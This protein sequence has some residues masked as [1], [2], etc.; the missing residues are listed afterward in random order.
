M[1]IPEIVP[2]NEEEKWSLIRTPS[3][4][5]TKRSLQIITSVFEEVLSGYGQD[6]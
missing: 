2:V 4:G 1:Q 3:T 5:V 6:T